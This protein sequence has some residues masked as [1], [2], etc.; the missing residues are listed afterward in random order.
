MAFKDLYVSDIWER[1][2]L[3]VKIIIIYP[4]F[5][6]YQM[7][8]RKILTF[9]RSGV[10]RVSKCSSKSCLIDRCR[11]SSVHRNTGR[12]LKEVL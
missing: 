7:R 12:R 2:I 6:C 3:W 10:R 8:N 11:S 1:S 5:Q 4:G 9:F